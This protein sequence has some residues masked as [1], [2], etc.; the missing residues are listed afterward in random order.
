MV[1]ILR[2]GTRNY[3]ADQS[4]AI[5][6]QQ[7]A[8]NIGEWGDVV[9]GAA[10]IYS[11]FEKGAE[12]REAERAKA[13]E[14]IINTQI[15][16][17]PETEL[18]KWNAA[19]IESG[20]DPNT[21]EYTKALYAKRDE[22][23]APYM[24]QM[25]SEKG[26]V[27]LESQGQK[28]A[29]KIRQSNIG[30]I[31]K[32]RQK[33][34]AKV[35]FDETVKNINNDA[36]EF[37]KLGDWQGFKAATEEDDKAIKKYAKANDIS[38][39]D[40]D[41]ANMLSFELG[42]AV[43]DPETILKTYGTKEELREIKRKEA[44]DILTK[45]AK[46]KTPGVLQR[47]F[48]G[49]IPEE[50]DLSEKQQDEVFEEWYIQGNIK[51]NAVQKK[52]EMLPENAVKQVTDAFVMS[53]KQEQQALRDKMKLLPKGS[54]EYKSFEAR[55]DEIQ[56]QI[57]NPDEY[58]ADAM[59]EDIKKAVFPVAK[60]QYEKNK[61]LEQK[62]REENVKEFYTMALNPNTSV[63]LPVQ[64]AAAL[65][66]PVVEDLFQMSL[67]DE[68][69]HRAYDAYAQAKTDVLTR[70][71]ATFE[72]T[73]ATAD[74]MYKFLSNPSTNEI[75]MFR[76]GFELLA[77]MHKAD[78]TQ[79]QWQD[80]NNIMYGVFKDRAF[81]DLAASVLE[82]NN[83]YFPDVPTI[84]R[85]G[86]QDIAPQEAPEEAGLPSNVLHK[87]TLSAVTT[88][89]D[90]ASLDISK[91]TVGLL[92]KAA[93]LDTPEERKQAIDEIRKFVANEK[94]K[95]YDFA[96]K[97]YGV[98]LAKLRE[99]KKQF[100]Q[101]FTQLG[102]RN[103]VEYMGDDPYS[104]KPL[105]RQLTDYTAISNARKRIIDGLEASKKQSKAGEE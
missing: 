60:E 43:T 51:E 79:E 58:V 78:L 62:M 99:N 26:R 54:K 16:G 66:Q 86:S 44:G 91:K 33:A 94:Q 102:S 61:L 7:V 48:P 41:K 31:A 13:D 68:E 82:D 103:V 14:Q 25:T 101:A 72:A 96:M 47:L 80:M 38:E 6:Q 34:Q 84:F 53:K 9:K 104:G 97:N 4:A 81:A 83:K 52:M 59:T 63:S 65:G 39:Y 12:A 23:Y 42:Q 71:Y 74:K 70:R 67:P 85:L 10:N 46:E 87:S 100:G 1:E 88:Y 49:L 30:K 90:K 98:D 93:Q 36:N 75:E 28:T 45:T 92:G 77:E 27:F 20:I 57:D 69:M 40:I 21:E 11:A 22:L 50:M 5:R 64:M 2:A 8:K 35:A 105:F 56:A 55:I 76:D 89:L 19:Q 18:L 17:K 37:G 15:S 95:A 3:V 32:N 29:E 24:E 73:E